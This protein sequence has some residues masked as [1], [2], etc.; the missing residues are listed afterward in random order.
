MKCAFEKYLSK[1]H[2]LLD[3]L[4]KSNFYPAQ[5]GV[6]AAEDCGESTYARGL[7]IEG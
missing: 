4:Q 6:L 7:L 5:G 2:L 1:A 3:F